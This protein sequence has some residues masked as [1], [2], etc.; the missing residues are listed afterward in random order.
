[1]LLSKRTIHRGDVNRAF[2]PSP[3]DVPEIP[4]PAAVPTVLYDTLNHLY[5]S[6]ITKLPV[7]ATRIDPDAA[8]VTPYGK[9]N[10]AW[11]KFPSAYPCVFPAST[12]KIPG[13]PGG[14]VLL[15]YKGNNKNEQRDYFA[16][17]E[18]RAAYTCIIAHF[19]YRTVW[20]DLCHLP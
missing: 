2:V 6:R 14:V 10:F 1:M 15:C 5:T 12:T 18:H 4:S 13:V 7:S 19:P 11:S 20:P 9:L 16:H 3:F 17:L 8:I